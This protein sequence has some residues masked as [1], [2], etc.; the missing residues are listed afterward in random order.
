MM[1]LKMIGDYDGLFYAIY[2]VFDC[3]LC[4]SKDN[5][6]VVHVLDESSLELSIRFL[7]QLTNEPMHRKHY[8]DRE[9][10]FLKHMKSK[11]DFDKTKIFV[12][13]F[14]QVIV[15]QYSIDRIS[16][17]RDRIYREL[18]SI[19]LLFVHHFESK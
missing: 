13:Y 9:W 12:I 17:D 5:L 3:V 18:F 7:H 4:L 16:M 1:T 19:H 8:N 11:L 14:D 15:V 10:K 6:I 2:P